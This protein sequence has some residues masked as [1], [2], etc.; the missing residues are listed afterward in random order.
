VYLVDGTYELFR[1]FHGA[2]RATG[3][4]G[5]EVGAGR[6]MFATLCALVGDPAVT[7]VAVAF[8][9]V[10]ARA[11]AKAWTDEGLIAAQTPL[12]AD[13]VRALGITIWP[14]GRFQ[15]DELLAS[16]ARRYADEPGVEQVVVCTTDVDLFQCI[17]GERVVVLDRSRQRVTTEAGVVERFGVP[18]A[19]LADLFAL[20]GDRSDGIAG[21]PG[22]GL[23]S[24]AALLAAF[25]ALEAIPNDS[26]AWPPSV[27]G[28]D[29]LAE[30]LRARRREALHCRDLLT[31][32]DDVPLHD[33][34]SELAWHGADRA[35]IA[36]IVER[37]AE[38]TL[39]ERVSRWR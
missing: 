4:D 36:E 12:A 14:A 1:C 21:V 26:A 19:L 27:R 15:A 16:G 30:A 32:R 3:A 5:H 25:G 2:P 31:L 34:L 39:A 33:E 13:V 8:D 6:G 10:V 23:R 37:L 29:R 22:W 7:H 20:V 9:S 11:G 17:R 28:R 24:A 38:P 18:P 35:A